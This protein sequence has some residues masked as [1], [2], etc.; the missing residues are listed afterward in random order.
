MKSLVLFF[1]GMLIFLLV[2]CERETS[3]SKTV[4]RVGEEKI[5][6]SELEKSLVL[7]PQYAIR[8]PLRQ[9]RQSQLQY[10]IDEKYYYLA[11]VAVG[12][13]KDP[14][15]AN[16]IAYIR[17]Q[18]LIKEYI[19]KNFLD[20]VELKSEA[21][22]QA[23]KMLDRQVK[24]RH[25]FV[26]EQERA[27]ELFNRLNSGESFEALAREIYSDSS[28]QASGGDL[29][30]IQ[31]GDLDPALEEKV[32]S[33]KPGEI[34]TPVKSAYGYHILQVTAI[35]QNE[36]FQDLASSTKQQLVNEILKARQADR[37]IREHLQE[38]A[39]QQKIQINNRVLDRLEEVT[40]EVIGDRYEEAEIFKPAIFSSDL[41]RIENDLESILNEELV[42]FGEK[43]LRVADFLER[44]KQMPPLHRPY[45]RTRNR[46]IQS[47]IDLIRNDLI[48]DEAKTKGLNKDKNLQLTTQKII[49]E[50]LAEEFQKRYYSEVLKNENAA[51]WQE[52]SVALTAVKAKSK[53]SL[54]PENLFFDV[55]NP[56][57]IFA[58]EPIP[59]FLK[60][61]YR[62]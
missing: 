1:I 25:L 16:R 34:S 19:R 15:I 57:S 32:F 11:A 10:L 56:D 59:L 44:L 23:L 62:W 60:N 31:F 39:G 13:E 53:T 51:E 42:R 3:S 18:E 52:Y 2:S 28:L 4:A 37:A 50:F 21:Q 33:M 48:L 61:R 40:R 27:Q 38:L 22:L 7:N 41:L 5:S 8:T 6:F 30:Y 20:R 9:V 49:Q 43:Q 35:E 47:I 55:K 26:A 14:V 54:Y 46:M 17:D 12:L 45:L 24:V 36:Q 29:G 58:P